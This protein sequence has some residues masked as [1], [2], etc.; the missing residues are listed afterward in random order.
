[1][2]RARGFVLDILPQAHNKVIDRAR[3]SIF[4]QAPNILE[5]HAARND[6]SLMI[7]QISQQLHFHQRQM[8]YLLTGSQLQ[9]FEVDSFPT[10]LENLRA[11]ILRDAITIFVEPGTTSQERID[12]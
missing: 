11:I 3:V 7:D 12:P 8:H 1:M 5:Y 6:P 2:P 10:K 4:T 9:R